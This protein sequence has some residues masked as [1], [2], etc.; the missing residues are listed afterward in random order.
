MVKGQKEFSS[1]LWEPELEEVWEEDWEDDKE[2]GDSNRTRMIDTEVSIQQRVQ[3]IDSGQ[4]IEEREDEE[5]QKRRGKKVEKA[6]AKN[7]DR[8]WG[9][10]IQLSKR[11]S[12][13]TRKSQIC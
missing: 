1:F 9:T 4:G 10:Y 7:I 5:E 12:R 2:D 13:Q 8:Y 6:E 3:R 11:S